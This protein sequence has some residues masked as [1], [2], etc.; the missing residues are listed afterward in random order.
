MLRRRSIDIQVRID[1]EPSVGGGRSARACPSHAFSCLKQDEQDFQD[2]AAWA[3]G[4]KVWKTLMSI[5]I[6]RNKMLRSERTLICHAVAAM[7]CEGQALALR[8][9]R[10]FFVVR[11]PVP[12]DR[13]L[14]LFILPIL[15]I[16][17]QTREILRTSR[18]FSPYC[19]YVL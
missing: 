11:G 17:L 13:S 12:R 14:I 18:T 8:V 10:R 9:P 16:L 7:P 19:A 2:R 5:E 3:Y 6:S 4:P 1:L 15:A